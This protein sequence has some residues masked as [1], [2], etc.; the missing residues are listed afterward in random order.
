MDDKIDASY[1][2][3]NPSGVIGEAGRE[4]RDAGK[5]ESSDRVSEQTYRSI[6]ENGGS[7]KGWRQ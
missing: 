6:F 4:K 1:A 2:T 5:P 3:T 7:P